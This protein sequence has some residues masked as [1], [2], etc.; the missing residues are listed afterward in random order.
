MNP[1]ISSYIRAFPVLPFV[2]LQIISFCGEQPKKIERTEH[3]D[4]STN[5]DPHILSSARL[6]IRS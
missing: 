4:Y 6:S 1:K 2:V 5:I 3:T